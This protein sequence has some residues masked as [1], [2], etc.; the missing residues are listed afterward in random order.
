MTKPTIKLVNAETGEEIER[1][2]NADEFATYQQ[3][4]AAHAAKLQ[5]EA[6]QAAAKQAILDRLGLT[7]EEAALLLS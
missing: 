7:V 2:M 1:E 3:D 5:A 4:A 6:S